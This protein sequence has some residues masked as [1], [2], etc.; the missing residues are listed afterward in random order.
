MFAILYFCNL[1]QN[2]VIS[3]LSTCLKLRDLH[4]KELSRLSMKRCNQHWL[5]G[6]LYCSVM[7]SARD[8]D[9]S[10]REAMQNLVRHVLENKY[11]MKKYRN[12]GD[13]KKHKEKRKKEIEGLDKT[14]IKS[15]RF[16]SCMHWYLYSRV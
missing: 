2:S 5:T 7:V 9:G 13:S 12:K 4:Q 10:V 11:S 8:G 1:I 6:S 15:V 14:G 16:L 3:E